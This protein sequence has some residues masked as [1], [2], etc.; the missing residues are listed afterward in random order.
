[1]KRF[2]KFSAYEGGTRC[3]DCGA[4]ARNGN[5]QCEIAPQAATRDELDAALDGWSASLR[6]ALAP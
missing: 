4:W 2:C 5:P 3:D 6:K 1:M